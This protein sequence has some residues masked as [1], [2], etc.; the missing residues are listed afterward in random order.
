[1][2]MR[3]RRDG[4]DYHYALSYENDHQRV[5]LSASLDYVEVLSMQTKKYIAIYESCLLA[6]QMFMF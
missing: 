3:K 4:R 1:M 2:F 6:C 5:C